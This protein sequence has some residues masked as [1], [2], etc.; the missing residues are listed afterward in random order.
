MTNASA[1]F[2]AIPLGCGRCGTEIPSALARCPGCGQQMF[3]SPGGGVPLSPRELLVANR[4]PASTG[5]RVTAYLVDVALTAG[6]VALLLA[7]DLWFG[8]GVAVIVSVAG[9][10]L[11]WF[12]AA[13]LRARDGRTPGQLVTKTVV[14]ARVP[15]QPV[16]IWRHLGR[17]ALL[18]LS[19]VLAF[20]GAFSV[21][22]DRGTPRRG[23][24]EKVSGTT[25]I[26]CRGSEGYEVVAAPAAARVADSGALPTDSF[27]QQPSTRTPLLGGEDRQLRLRMDDGSYTDLVGSGFLGVPAVS[28]SPV[29][30]AEIVAAPVQS[31]VSGDTHLQFNVSGGRLWMISTGPQPGSVL[32]DGESVTA[33][34]PGH[35]YEVGLGTVVH[36]GQRSFEVA[37]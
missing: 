30:R 11:C 20:M 8:L 22:V 16:G 21:A 36:L 10:L 4:I 7:A 6:L 5:A 12:A 2:E 27:D 18:H 25:V 9:P 26:N 24:H 32:D 28:W 29:G 19:N 3:V 33:M 23:W 14:A 17:T 15:G 35:P 31:A 37:G 34:R 13:V 1:D